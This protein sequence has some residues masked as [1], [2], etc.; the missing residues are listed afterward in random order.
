MI[1]G[2]AERGH[3]VTF[4]MRSSTMPVRRSNF[5]QSLRLP[6]HLFAASL[7]CIA[8]AV[9]ALC[10]TQAAAAQTP[11]RIVQSFNDGWR[12]AAIDA[13]GAEQPAFND[14]TWRTLSVPH[15]WSNEGRVAETNPSGQ[16]GGFAPTG[17]GWYRKV[18]ALPETV[19][20]RHSFIVF[21]GVMANSDV[22]INGFHL[23]RRPYGYI[24]FYYEL[25]GHLRFG[26][27]ARNVL[28]VRYDNA[29]QPASRWYQG[30]GIY[31][32]VRLVVTQNLHLEPWSVFVSTPTITNAGATVQVQSSVQNDSSKPMPTSVSITLIAPDGRSV[33]M[34]SMPMQTIAAQGTAKF[35]ADIQVPQPKLWD[36][37]HPSLYKALVQVKT[38][39]TITDDDTQPFGIR[40][41]HFDADTGFWLNGRNF[42]IKGA[43]L[44][45]DGGAVGTAVPLATYERRL[46]ELRV[47]GVNAIRTAH[48]PPSPEFLDLCDRLGFLVM[49]EMFDCWT[50]GKNP[51][52][53][54][55][56]FNEW[57]TRDLSDTVRRDR[58]HPSIILWSAGNEIHDT[59]QPELAKK[60]LSGLVAE[61]HANDPTRPVTQALFRPNASHD[62]DDGLADLLDVVG[63]NYRENELLAAHAQKPTRK[64][65][66]TENTLGRP[67]W[68]AMRDHPEYSAQFLWVG[69]DYLG[70]SGQWPFIANG[71]GLLD[72]SGRTKAAGLERE[73]WWSPTPNI[74]IARRIGP[75]DKVAIDP[76]YES[77]PP[78]FHQSLYMD[79]TPADRTPHTEAVEVYTNADEVDLLLNGTS[80][81]RQKLHA[82]ASPLTWKVPFAAGKLTAVAYTAGKEVAR[83]ELQTAGKA[84]AVRLT[85][86]Q[87]SFTAG[88]T[89][90]LYLDADVVDANGVVVPDATDLLRFEVKGSTLR[91]VDNGSLAD[92]DPFQADTR[93]AFQGRAI[94]IVQADHVGEITVTATS[95][96]LQPATTTAHAKASQESAIPTRSF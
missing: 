65:V 93:H 7:R 84:V 74:H 2:I 26:T 11:V 20:H 54:H 35:S 25:T 46:L 89:G 48:N 17:I 82:D 63:Q 51:Y 88:P 22:W 1:V 41:F 76:G 95:P 70:E 10:I 69:V 91:A 8:A 34:Q 24:S 79:W 32:P 62:Y 9:L 68:L 83:D 77:V 56:Y 61:F 50:V 27:K 5:V 18:F 4:P 49:D 53:Y 42:K 15:D 55:L 19:A 13:Q 3:L 80:L 43:A 58:N 45:I 52:D 29:Q 39:S 87:P 90:A 78:K 85:P 64:I 33:A 94:V 30:S 57:A 37:D 66:G 40:E 23:G 47:L 71:S 36:L 81:G 75:N 31:R 86:E 28:A 44:H 6:A 38:G 72:K 12:F 96:A 16:G 73:S 67:V 21:D 60:I 14:S 59:P 92:D